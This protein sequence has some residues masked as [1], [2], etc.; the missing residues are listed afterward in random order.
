MNVGLDV[1]WARLI[2]FWESKGAFFLSVSLILISTLLIF[3][4]SPVFFGCNGFLLLHLLT[5]KKFYFFNFLTTP[6]SD[7]YWTHLGS[8][9]FLRTWSQTFSF[10]LIQPESPPHCLFK[11]NVVGET[12]LVSFSTF[13]YFFFWDN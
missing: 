4:L 13:M 12:N 11:S 1:L 9:Q 10:L 5:S 7:W 2:A 3:S 6:W 8:L